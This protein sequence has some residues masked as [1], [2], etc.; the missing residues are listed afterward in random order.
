MNKSKKIILWISLFFWSPTVATVQKRRQRSTGRVLQGPH[1]TVLS[2]AC[3]PFVTPWLW[4]NLLLTVPAASHRYCEKKK[5][6]VSCPWWAG[7]LRRRWEDVGSCVPGS[8]PTKT[9]SYKSVLSLW[10]CFLSHF[11]DNGIPHL[12]PP[13]SY[14]TTEPIH[15]LRLHPMRSHQSQFVQK[16]M[17]SW[18]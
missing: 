6:R 15:C 18:I 17:Q 2:A 13:P 4:Q 7:I 8:Q 9:S 11:G 12:P 5:G 16:N 14:N 10:V 1:F 3:F